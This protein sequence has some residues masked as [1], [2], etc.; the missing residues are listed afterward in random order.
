MGYVAS[1][2]AAAAVAHNVIATIGSMI[3][4]LIRAAIAKVLQEDQNYNDLWL[5]IKAKG[6]Y[7]H[8]YYKVE[9]INRII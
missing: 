4:T 7:I 3:K 1:I 5:R 8:S 6:G 9:H 2:A